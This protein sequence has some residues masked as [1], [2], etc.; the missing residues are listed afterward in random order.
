MSTIVV[1]F[2]IKTDG[3]ITFDVGLYCFTDFDRNVCMSKLGNIIFC[4]F[5]FSVF[6]VSYFRFLF[7]S[8]PRLVWPDKK[9]LRR[10]LGPV[11]L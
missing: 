4:M 1:H 8:S 3:M 10:Y 11:L 9:N 7:T 6:S 2:T 5:L